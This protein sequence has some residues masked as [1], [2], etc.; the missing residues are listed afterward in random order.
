MNIITTFFEF[1]F[2][3]LDQF[4]DVTWV[5]YSSLWEGIET[6]NLY[7]FELEYNLF[8]IWEN[9]GAHIQYGSRSILLM[10]FYLTTIIYLIVNIV[11]YSN[12]KEF[13]FLFL[14][15]FLHIFT[16]FILFAWF[17]DFVISAWS[18]NKESMHFFNNWIFDSNIVNFPYGEKIDVFFFPQL[19][20]GLILDENIISFLIAFFLLGGAEEEE[21]EDFI[22]EEEE[23]D[24]IEDI[25]APLFLTN[26]GKDVEDNGALF[27]KVCSVFGFVLFNNLMGII[28][29]TN[30]ATSGLI[31][32]LWV[33]ISVFG[34]LIYLMLRKHGINYFFNL[35]LPAGAP[36]ALMFLL[37]PIEVISYTFRCVSLSVR[38]FANMFAGHTLLKVIVGF[39]WSMI[40][41]GDVFLL[42]NFF[43][44]AILFILTFLEIGVAI[45]QA[46][47]F[48]TLTCLYLRDIFVS[49]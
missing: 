46:Y 45:V 28:P 6:Y 40:L 21:D 35:F 16:G 17:D 20:F 44:I 22:L 32:T 5:F 41:V 12:V 26:L 9:N 2:S 49:H 23:G 37:I 30:T 24:F 47:I 42:V 4:D 13:S 29:Y 7:S 36:L 14:L 27:L 8:S 48:T 3:P 1:N 31:L 10:F 11:K 43:P 38:L 39:S 18:V 33:S 15:G 34:S 25:V 19:S